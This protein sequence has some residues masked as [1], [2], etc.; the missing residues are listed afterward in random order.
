MRRALLAITGTN[1]KT[2]T[3]ALT[4]AAGRA[5]RPACG[6][7]RQHRPDLL[8]TL[9]RAIDASAA[10]E[11]VPLP[12]VWVLELSSFQLDGDRHG[13][14]PTAAA[15]LNLSQDHLDWHGDMQAYAAAKARIFGTQGVMVINRDDA[16]VRG[17]AA[18]P[19]SAPRKAKAP[20]PAPRAVIGFGLGVPDSPGDFGLVEQRHGLAGAR[21]AGRGGHQAAQGRS[22][23]KIAP[24]AA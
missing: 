14:E 20:K 10:D 15:V 22:L 6:G 3:T 21:P 4:R 2:T 11:P 7:G 24:A 9:A 19:E 17:H 8:D 16:A 13:F 1:G 23:P 18:A 5:R 12:E